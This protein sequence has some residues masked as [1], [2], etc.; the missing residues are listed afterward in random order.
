MHIVAIGTDH[1][2][3]PI[4]LRERL[5][6][7][8]RLLPEVLRAAQPVVQENVLLATCSRIEVYAI[9]PDISGGR[10]ISCV[11]SAKL[12]RLNWLNCK[13]IVI[14]LAMKKL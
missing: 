1:I 14:S 5:V 3:A 6:S 2:T 10:T 4:A 8:R 13:R 9:S 7:A 12:A 11:S